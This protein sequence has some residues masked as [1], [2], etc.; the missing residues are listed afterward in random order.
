MLVKIEVQGHTP[1]MLDRFGEDAEASVSSGTSISYKG[2]K[3]TPLEIAT[4]KLYVGRNGVLMIPNPNMLSCITQAGTFFKTGKRQLTTQKSSLIPACVEI[5]EI[6]IPLV[7]KE[8][9]TV[10]TRPVRIPSTGGRILA[11]RPIFNDWALAFNLNVDTTLMPIKL[12]RDVV[13]AA[14]RRVG[15]G[16]F[17]PQCKG[18][19]G[20]FVVTGWTETEG[21]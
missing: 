21:T 12:M 4:K 15:L 3:G 18:P 19:Y 6:E 11:H 7:H 14:G 9:W 2:D 17:R 10:D 1:L 13:D 8:P 16:A 20:K 5:E